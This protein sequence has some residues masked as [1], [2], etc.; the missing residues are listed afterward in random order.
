MIENYSFLAIIPARKGSK[1]L[2]N[3]NITMLNNKPLI[4]YTIEAANKSNSIDKI[5]LT[6]DSKSYSEIAKQYGDFD[7]II[8]SE[9]LSS[10]KASMKDVILDVLIRLKAN[11]ESYDYFM[12][13][14]P[15]SPLR[16]S[17]HII[18]AVNIVIKNRSNSLVSLCELDH[19]SKLIVRLNNKNTLDNCFDDS[20]SYLR[21]NYGKE[22]RIN[23]AIFIC[24]TEYYLKFESFYKE[25][26]IPYI[27][28]RI[29]SVDI[30]DIDDLN[31]AEYLIKKSGH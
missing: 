17:K 15:T 27:M 19:P 13:L 1:G 16:Q 24:K 8:R 11:G 25:K 6:T 5:I 9:E 26:S 21:Q 29:S 3:K 12:L 20:K 2:I 4:A 31:Y 18:E 22:Y 30:D 23:G 28:D 10:D 14:Q 7:T